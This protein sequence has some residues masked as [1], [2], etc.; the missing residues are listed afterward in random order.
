[1]QSVSRVIA[2]RCRFVGT[3]GVSGTVGY[4]TGHPGPALRGAPSTR[5]TDC[6][7]YEI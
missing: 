4:S 2:N 1:M 5:L 6:I 7:V 3:S